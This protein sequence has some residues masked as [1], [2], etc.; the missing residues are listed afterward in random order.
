[1]SRRTEGSLRRHLTIEEQVEGGKSVFP[2]GIGGGF[3]IVVGGI[4]RVNQ[5]GCGGSESSL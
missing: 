3:G 5:A 2:T 1:M 4:R